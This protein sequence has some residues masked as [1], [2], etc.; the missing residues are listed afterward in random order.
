[1]LVKTPLNTAI[2]TITSTVT[3]PTKYSQFDKAQTCI[4]ELQSWFTQALSLNEQLNAA[5]RPD[6][7]A[8]LNSRSVNRGSVKPSVPQFVDCK[9]E[10]LQFEIL[11][12]NFC[13]AKQN[14]YAAHREL[15]VI[16]KALFSDYNEGAFNFKQ[17]QLG[18]DNENQA[19]AARVNIVLL[20]KV[21]RACGQL[22]GHLND[23]PAYPA[24]LTLETLDARVRFDSGIV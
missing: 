5:Q 17:D 19:I 8:T 23:L 4:T 10:L 3:L 7:E 13:Q 18:F 1:M 21:Y 24:S 9:D 14:F 22:A 6:I 12:L 2:E 20:A 16:L 15:Y 11:R